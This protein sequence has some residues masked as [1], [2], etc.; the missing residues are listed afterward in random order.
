[1]ALGGLR[2]APEEARRPTL[3]K[4]D[5]A[6]GLVIAKGLLLQGIHVGQLL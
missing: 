3:K 6:A 2:G 5:T 1:M 4:L